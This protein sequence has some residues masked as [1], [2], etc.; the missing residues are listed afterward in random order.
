MR[1][2]VANFDS[3]QIVT[4]EQV[5]E[6]VLALPYRH[7]S[8]IQVIRY[9][10]SRT[11]AT[12]LSYLSEQPSV[13]SSQGLFYHDRESAVIVLFGFSSRAQFY[14]VL[15]HEIGHYVF[16]RRLD[17]AQRD[18]WMYRIR[19]AEPGTVSAYA[20]RN[21]REDFAETYAFW[22]TRRERLASFPMRYTFFAERVFGPDLKP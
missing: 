10:P 4:R 18:V 9:D 21:S 20:G 16:L 17:Q 2:L 22:C 13:I 11:I 6:A 12:T 1:L 5:V 3:Q 8:G 14:H 7:I 15:Y 19:K